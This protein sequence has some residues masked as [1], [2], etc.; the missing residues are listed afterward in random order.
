[1]VRRVVLEPMVEVK[2]ERV[3]RDAVTAG[4]AMVRTTAVALLRNTTCRSNMIGLWLVFPQ[5]SLTLTPFNL[6]LDDVSYHLLHTLPTHTNH[7]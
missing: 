4:R 2:F 1:M 7:D 3:L 5:D 6:I